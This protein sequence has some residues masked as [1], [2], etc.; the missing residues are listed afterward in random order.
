MAKQIKPSLAA[1]KA[2]SKMKA[3]GKKDPLTRPK[4]S[5]DHKKV[6]SLS[7]DEMALVERFC[8]QHHI[9]NR[10]K[11]FREAILQHILMKLEENYPKLF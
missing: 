8:K 9:Q 6:I 11:F 1:R 7:D 3:S 2:L 5:R 4:K 10:S